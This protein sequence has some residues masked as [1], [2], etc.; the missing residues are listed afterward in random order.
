MT[1]PTLEQTVSR[2]KSEILDDI[3]K[4]VIP[5]KVNSFSELHDYVDANTYGGFCEDKVA[6]A[7]IEFFGGRT[8]DEGM[9]EKF[10]DYMNQAQ[11]SI[12]EWLYSK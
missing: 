11:T 10:H 4:G 3:N 6:D 8:K 7:L 2:M 12:D 5:N 9:P 1:V